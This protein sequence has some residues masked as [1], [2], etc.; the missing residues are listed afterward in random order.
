MP[1]SR[2]VD[3]AVYQRALVLT[4]DHGIYPEKKVIVITGYNTWGVKSSDGDLYYHVSYDE[5]EGYQCNCTYYQ[6]KGQC[7]HIKAI[8]IVKE[9]SI[10]CPMN[11]DE[12]EELI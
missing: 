1:N 7:K 11:G 12:Q 10:Y 4:H 5:D 2:D 8:K 9:R 3:E 6:F